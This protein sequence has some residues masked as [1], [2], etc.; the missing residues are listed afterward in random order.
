MIEN[1]TKKKIKT[2]R[3]DNCEK[4]TSKEFK[5]LCRE[6][7]IKRELTTPYDPQQNGVAERKNR[8]IME[9]AR[10]LLHDQDLPIHLWAE[11]TRTSVYVQNRIPHRVLENKT[12]E[13]VLS[14]KKP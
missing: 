8:T 6:P 7:G 2:F 1:H 3:S 5:E 13:E 11:A 12:L 14:G 10:A 9:V 4:F